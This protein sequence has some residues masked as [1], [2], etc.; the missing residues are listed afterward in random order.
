MGEPV[1]MHDE[2]A[3]HCPPHAHLVELL[4]HPLEPGGHRAVLLIE[5]LLGA[6]RVVGQ[7]VS[8]II[9]ITKTTMQI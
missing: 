2:N 3:L 7:G 5:G 8:E 6:K 9:I 4:T 1:F